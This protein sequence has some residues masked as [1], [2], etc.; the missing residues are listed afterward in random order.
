MNTPASI[1]TP[2]D[3]T[4]GVSG[5]GYP[6]ISADSHI[7]EPPNCYS[8]YIDPAYRDR[9]PKIVER[10]GGDEFVVDGMPKTIAMGLVAA[11]GKKAEE[12][13]TK[14]VRFADLHRG[15][16]DPSAR[17]G[18]QVRDGVA[19]EIIYPTV[20]MV[21]CNLPDIDYKK[22]CFDA[23]NRWISE[24]CSFDPVR[25]LG[26]GQTAMRTP[27]E[28]IEDLHAIKAAGLRGVMMP[29]EPG[30]E[31]YDS[32]IYDAFY[33]EAV[34]LGLPLSWHIL[35]TKSEKTRGPRLNTFLS[36]VRGCQDIMGMLIFGWRVRT[37][38]GSEGRVRGGRR[39][40]G[41]ALHVSHGPCVQP[42]PLLAHGRHTAVAEAERVLLAEHLHDVPGRLDRVPIRRRD[43]LEAPA[44]GERL[45]A[46]G[47]DV[48]VVAGAARRAHREPHGPA[49]PG[50]PAGEHRGAVRHRRAGA[51]AG[52]GPH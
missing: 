52:R 21:L 15:G 33:R 13:T 9:A 35:T 11:A 26:C 5:W 17:I 24:Y 12:I 29:G 1:E 22:A 14:G 19:A 39:G 50:D 23:Y 38:P 46:F 40:L 45:P 25:L 8:D 20:G 34:D 2:A 27:E 3:P 31:D 43:E 49:A 48:A 6:V 51:D 37:Q 28:G 4:V 32:P 10:N 18:D 44:V 42:A 36:I 16:W 41:A 30:L 7:T 47:L